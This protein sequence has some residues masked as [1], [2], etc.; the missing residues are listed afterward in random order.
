MSAPG[1]NYKEQDLSAYALSTGTIY[2]AIV[3]AAKKGPVEKPTVAGGRK[4]FLQVFTPNEAVEVGFST[5]HF[6]A[7]KT[8]E[9]T[10]NLVV[11]RAASQD[12]RYAGVTFSTATAPVGTPGIEDPTAFQF[13]AESFL[14]AASS[15]GD[16]GKDLRVSILGYKDSESCD[17]SETANQIK[18]TQ[19]W[20]KGFPVKV[21]GT[22]PDGLNP[23]STYFVIAAATGEIALAATQA[24]AVASSPVPIAFTKPSTGKIRISPAINY[25]KLPNTFLIRVFNKKDLNNPVLEKVASKSPT[26]KDADNNSLYLEDVLSNNN[27]V[28]GVDNPLVTD[29]MPQDVVI[30]VALTGGTDGSALTTADYIRALQSL[31]NTKEFA[32]KV[33]QDGGITVVDYH[34]ALINLCE[35]RADCVPVLSAP[36]S[37]QENPLT[38]AQDIVN[39]RKFDANY[40]TSYGALYAP[41]QKVYDEFNDREVW[42]APDGFVTKAIF[43]TASNYE[44]WYPV[45]GDKRGVI[46]SRDCKI[47]FL[48]SDEDLLYDNGIN[49]IIFDAGRGIKIWGQKTLQATP[50]MTDR[51]N[52][53]LMLITIGPAIRETLRGFL[54]DFNDADTRASA[55]AIIDAYM[56]NVQGR[57]GVEKYVSICDETNNDANDIDNHIMNFDL[58]VCPK[59][60]T[61]WINFRI[62]ITNN[63]VDFQL[64]AAAL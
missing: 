22:L 13:N 54:F 58:L 30:P 59:N 8:L 9:G 6:S 4:R 33:M 17:F 23:T 61:E 20:G 47:H 12:A 64:A 2:A 55:K 3:L 10:D 34:D 28:L 11:V 31:S 1:V 62:G 29:L 63:S 14:L 50:S 48:E 35:N 5:G 16:W 36:L 49:P 19:K 37:V 57:K 7:L 26:A 25:T 60:S 21:S 44:I 32:I 24:N 18:V 51:L 38:A 42:V 41:H 15:Q 53:R 39:W 27:Y 40:N 46:N 56:D 43:D 45:G 52:V